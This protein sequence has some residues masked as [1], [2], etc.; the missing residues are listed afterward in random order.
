MSTNPLP[1][2]PPLDLQE[3]ALFLDFDGTLVEIAAKPDAIRVTDGLATRLENLSAAV[4]GRLALISGRFLSDIE[5]HLGPV[6]VARAGS[7][8]ADLRDAKGE[9]VGS[10]PEPMPA[11]LLETI[12]AFAAHEE[13]VL[14]EDKPHG[15][16]LHYRARPEMK[17]QVEAFADTLAAQHDLGIKRGKMVVELM[18]RRANKAE[19]V[20]T[21]MTREPFTGHTPVFVGDDVTDEDGFRAAKA[22]GGFG[23]L[24]GAPRETEAAYRLPT[25]DEVHGWLTP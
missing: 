17:A 4:G 5:R 14:V 21:F 9:P 7:H 2:P 25:V 1:P 13:G 6:Q 11:S 8:G 10:A 20:R 18:A 23:I 24:V 19:A 3:T 16:G 12:K 22:L 15:T